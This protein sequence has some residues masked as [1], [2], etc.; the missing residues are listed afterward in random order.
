MDNA[1]K[2][3][4]KKIAKLRER[5]T[6]TKGELQKISYCGDE[7]EGNTT[8]N[9]E[10]EFIDALKDEMPEVFKNIEANFDQLDGLEFL[11]KEV[12]ETQNIDKMKQLKK[13]VD[14]ATNKVEQSESL[15]TKLENE[16]IEW[17]I[18]KKLCTR[19]EELI[20]I[21]TLLLDFD[22]DLKGELSEMEKELTKNQTKNEKE[23]DPQGQL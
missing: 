4:K 18:V 21:D 9:E 19:D 2:I 11:L 13:E 20:E 7:M 3:L 17:N 8:V 5:L 15:S 23:G 10:D 16:I 6:Q 14:D 12:I 1:T 22:D